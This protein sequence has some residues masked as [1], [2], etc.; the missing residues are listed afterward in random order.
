MRL[1]PRH[2]GLVLLAGGIA[3]PG[4]AQDFPKK[5]IELVVP[6][7]AGGTTDNIARLIAQRF[8]DA[9]SATVV[10]NSRP[11][12]GGSIGA[13]AVA[14]APPDGHTLLV[15]TIG[16]AITPAMQKLPFDPIRDF[17]PVTELASLPLMLVV[18]PSVPAANLREFIA[19]VKSQPGKWDY[20]SAGIGTSPHLAGEMF[21]A[22]A[23]VD[24]VHVPF[25]GNSEVANALLGGHI[26]VYFSLAPASLQHVRAGTLRVLAVTTEKRLPYL[27]DVPT[28]AESGFPDYEISSW[29]GLFAPGGTPGAIVAKINH[30]V[31]EMLQTPDVQAR[32]R[33]E[34][35]DPV[36]S[37]PAQF[38]A[39]V[40]GELDK[41][42]K[43]VKAAGLGVQN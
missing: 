6:Y 2:V 30:E 37:S 10:V 7:T 22:M 13:A 1:R 23:G 21:K 29:Q 43:V 34:G 19:L 28:I 5:P 36:G 35:A 20:A 9:W 38:T 17:A 11:G 32:I 4:F 25:K 31:V 41:W 39:R 26:K 14:K 40:K 33:R 16:F 18:H 3:L 15:A 12:G 27:P 8:A 42:A 24:L